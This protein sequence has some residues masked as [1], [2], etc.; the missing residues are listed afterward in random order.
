MQNQSYDPYQS[1]E[2]L[3]QMVS[4]GSPGTRG[5]AS[6]PVS[7]SCHPPGKSAAKLPGSYHL[8]DR[9]FL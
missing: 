3:P 9:G 2:S 5:A 6:G 8:K 7:E 4:P 1:L